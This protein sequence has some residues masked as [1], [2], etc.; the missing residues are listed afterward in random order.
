M[1]RLRET[2]RR[3]D[4]RGYKAYKDIKGLSQFPGFTV[5]I[6]HVQGDPFADASRVSVL[7]PVEGT[8]IES[9]QQVNRSRNIGLCNF[10]IA[11]FADAIKLECK[12]NR[13]S[14][15]SGLVSID[16]P[17][18]EMLPRSACAIDSSTVEIRF[19]MGLPAAGRSVLARE[20][21]AMFFQELP[22]V[23]ERCLFNREGTDKAWDY[24]HGNEDADTLRGELARLGL[25][26]FVAEGSVLPRHSGIDDRPMG[27]DAVPFGPAPEAFRH[28]VTLPNAGEVVGMGIPRG[29]TLIVGG[30]YHGKSTLLNA[31]ARGVYNHIPGD[32]RELVVTEPS[33]ITIRAEDGRRVEKVNISSFIDNLPREKSTQQFCSKDASGSTSQASNIMEALEAGSETLVID[34]DTSATNFMIRDH[35]MQLLVARE[36]E[37]IIP[38]VDRVQELHKLHSVSTVLVLGGSGDYFDVADQVIQMHEYTPRDVTEEARRICADFPPRRNQEGVRPMEMPTP[39]YPTDDSL[40]PSR[41]HRAEK[42]RS[43]ETRSILFGEEEIDISQVEQLVNA[44]QTRFIADVMLQLARSGFQSQSLRESVE[45]VLARYQH[46]GFDALSPE[47]FGNRCEARLQEV[48]CAINRLRTMQIGRV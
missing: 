30:G 42:V 11:R 27:K 21:E 15:K 26:S 40:D 47:R 29:V 45:S 2:L 5:R 44:S 8:W 17:G 18:Q 35:R 24:V 9:A 19:R 23:V 4:R 22:A 43:M 32:G 3:I 10:V 25:V 34:E 20:A 39:R 33:A 37:P 48:L 38:F 14:G 12:Q 1:D 41:G 13:G 6:D 28:T 31:I 46:G 7:V 16:H 36:Q